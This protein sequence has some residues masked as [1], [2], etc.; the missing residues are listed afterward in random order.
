MDDQ[1]TLDTDEITTSPGL[2]AQNST[3]RNKPAAKPAA[4]RRN[5]FF[6][7]LWPFMQ[8]WGAALVASCPVIPTIATMFTVVFY[9]VAPNVSDWQLVAWGFIVAGIV[10]L[11]IS[12]PLSAFTSARAS[13]PQNYGLIESRLSRLETRL[14]VLQSTTSED[15]LKQYQRVALEEAYDN[16]TKLQEVMY[17]STSRLPWVLAWGY[18]N[19]WNWLHRT[20]EALIKIEPIEMVVSGAYHDYMAISNSKM[21]NCKDLLANLTDATKKL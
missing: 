5:G 15:Q 3:D 12:I 21:D 17:S 11:A 6:A 19:A 1:L 16:L 20:E 2:I 14:F 18:V 13:N 4:R 7:R 10:W 8:A 9:L